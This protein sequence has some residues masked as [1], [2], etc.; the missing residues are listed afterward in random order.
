VA[1]YKRM[2]R[3]RPTFR[4]LAIANYIVQ[5]STFWRRGLLDEIGLFDESLRYCFDYDFWMRAI[6]R[7]P[8][9]VLDEPLS[10]FRVHKGSKGGSE[11]V[12][13]FE[14]EHEVLR[15]YTADKTL[16]GLHRLHAALIVFAYRILKR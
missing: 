2:L 6:R 9:H 13:Q 16:L 10:F 3:R 4:T 5:P 14:E 15:L 12:K 1:A 8:L 11:F 7:Y